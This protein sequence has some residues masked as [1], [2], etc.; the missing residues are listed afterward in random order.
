M[1][2]TKDQNRCIIKA[3]VFILGDILNQTEH[4]PEK[5]AIAW[6]GI[7]DWMI[8]RAAFQTQPFFDSVI[9]MVNF[10]YKTDISHYYCPNQKEKEI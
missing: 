9:L 7:L 1:R 6:A 3:V 10:N 4:S 8:P 2:V 5:P